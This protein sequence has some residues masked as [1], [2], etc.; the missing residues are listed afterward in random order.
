MIKQIELYPVCDDEDNET[1][2]FI[3]SLDNPYFNAYEL[4]GDQVKHIA[5]VHKWRGNSVAPYENM[6]NGYMYDSLAYLC[7]HADKAPI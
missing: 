3:D 6:D 1:D 4:V 5:R 7:Y 2:Y